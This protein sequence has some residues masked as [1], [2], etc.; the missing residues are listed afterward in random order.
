[1]GEEVAA[2]QFSRE[3]RQRYRDKVHRCLD[4]FARMLAEHRFEQ[5]SSSMGLEIELNLTDAEGLPSMCNATVLE[6]IADAD[7]QTEL[8]Q[9]NVEIN[10]AP[11]R[12]GGRVLSELEEAVRDTLNS[13]EA[14]GRTAGAHM[15]LIGILPTIDEE[16]LNADAL[17]A[18]PRYALLNE[19][20]FAARGEDLHIDIAGP[21]QLRTYADTIA[22][23]AAC[24]SVQLHQLVAPQ[25]FAR[26]WNAAQ[27]IAAIQVGVGANSPF[28]FAR[29]LWRETRIALFEQAT[30]T[31]PE[32]LKAQGV[33]PRVWFGERWATSI[34]DLFEEN[35]RYFGALL[36]A[37]YDEE[38]FEALEQGV[39]PRL[40]ELRL[41][42]GTIYRWNRPIY[43]VVGNCP[44]LRVENRVLPAGPTVADI[45]ANAALY[46]GLIRVLVDDDRPLW[47]RM[48][49]ATA[50]EN[51]HAA[52]RDGIDARLYWPGVGEVPVAELVLRRLLPLA[53][54][55]LERWGVDAAD[56]ERL[57]GIVE[58][59]CLG[60]TNGATWQAETVRALEERGRSR[61]EA[62]REMTVRYRELMHANEPVH[63][64]PIGG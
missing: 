51:F 32:E 23:E 14:K 12:L 22:P 54:E 26:H 13:A 24:T 27:A 20:I 10:V 21:E 2:T 56:R 44:H 7:F 49:F 6:R 42:N 64:W 34:F 35:V 52:A 15:M 31:R 16:H 18:N 37:M 1:M 41:H 43:D 47:T 63:T 61:T 28:F 19:Q 57:L 58:G 29:E 9:F 48:S 60:H 55:G 46:Y 4:A 36:P 33:R 3:D 62:L 38:P 40:G 45:L 53:H 50:E 17:S 39:T 8:A 25:D 11:R 30:D 5:D 59:R